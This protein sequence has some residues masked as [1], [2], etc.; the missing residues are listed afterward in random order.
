MSDHFNLIYRTGIKIYRIIL[1]YMKGKY[2]ALSQPDQM[3]N[4]ADLIA[5]VDDDP[6]NLKIAQNIL[7]KNGM[8]VVA[9]SSGAQL[10]DF[11]RKD[12]P[13][14]ILL[15]IMMPEMDGF[16]TLT[17]IRDLENELD[18][19]DIPV[20]FLTSDEG[21]SSE[22]RGFELGISDYIRKPFQP[23][24]LIKRITNVLKR[25]AIIQR[26][27]EEAT[28][29]TLTGLL[30]KGATNNKLEMLIKR[31]PGCLMMI[32][33]DAFKLINDIYGHNAG[34][35]ILISFSILLKG[36]LGPDDIIGRMGGDE[37]TAFST[38]LKTEEDLK[39]FSDNLNTTL[40]LD[41]KRILGEEMDIPLGASIG[42]IFLDGKGI[43]YVDALK[44]A[45]KALYNV[46]NNGKH[47]YSLYSG[48][49][50]DEEQ[51]VLN[52]RTLSM[53]L[54]ERNMSSNALKLDSSSFVGVYRFVMRYVM[55]YHRNACKLLIT[56]HP[57]KGLTTEEA[58]DYFEQFGKHV[59]ETLRRSDLVMQ[60]R[61]NVYFVLL[62]DIRAGADEQVAGNIIRNWRSKNGDVLQIFYE[63]DFLES[64][65]I[66][67]GSDKKLWVAIV[68]DDEMNRKLADR[69]LS[70]ND[71]VVTKLASGE[72]LINF[73]SDHRPDLILLDVNMPGMDGFETLD[74]LRSKETEIAD[75]PVVFLTA[76][77]DI[78]TEKKALG[79]GA[80][81]FIKKPFIPEILTLRVKQIAELLRL[82]KRLEDEVSKKTKENEEL[83][84]DVV[85]SLA[86][87]ID[88]K[89]TYT[90]GHSSR[91]AE[92]S[93][94]IARRYGYS[95]KEQSDI[96]IMGLLHDVGKI[97]VPDSI[98]NKP[99]HLT[100][101]EF[102]QIKSH[103]VIGSQILK[104]I[105][106]MPKLS[107]GARWHHEK[108]DGTGYPDGLAGEE[109]PEEARIIA[110]ADAY[111]AMSSKRSYRNIMP[112]EK[113]RSE[114]IR[115]SGTQF[116]PRFAEIMVRMIDE[117][118]E[119]F[120]R[121]GGKE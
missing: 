91:V 98:I 3:I 99:G 43:E 40:I 112:Q 7:K 30:N 84:L 104:N 69:I 61:K 45:D 57:S 80:K 49:D 51:D 111:D 109:I 11:L 24:V 58:D 34:D 39:E 72:E 79:L 94:E 62:T 89:D 88:A 52:M 63:T 35:K 33:L 101:E 90:N 32:D 27:H 26:Y 78:D 74:I 116:D 53:I 73:L 85:S 14:L 31:K 119:Y 54:S 59:E 115:G 82:Q 12:T 21:N 113:I 92:Y 83:F 47:G 37:F 107:T 71:I 42:A 41:A 50:D 16:E 20:I 9:M 68:D 25:Q 48:S 17:K 114:I 38:S 60:V 36:F 46:K 23:A 77:N 29:D 28:T 75:I 22:T 106:K 70:K 65:K 105:K 1:N 76:E 64:E 13:D 110:V 108:Y 5:L 18:M 118:T 120:M 87:A 44:L 100:D 117:D 93:K 103:P 55:Q 102:E 19:D 96:Y 121:E 86:G 4:M 56:L 2:P 81:D 67:T 8:E 6:L 95:M 66:Y 10:L 97:G 15:D